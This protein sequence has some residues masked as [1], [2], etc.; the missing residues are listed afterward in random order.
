VLDEL[1]RYFGVN[2]D[3]NV[4]FVVDGVGQHRNIVEFVG[5]AP[6]LHQRI[7]AGEDGAGT[8]F[9]SAR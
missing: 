8:G 1:H 5:L 3:R 4:V 2:Q 7:G 9:L 6:A